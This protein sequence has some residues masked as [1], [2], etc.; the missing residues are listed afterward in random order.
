[1]KE[2]LR[3]LLRDQPSLSFALATAE[4]KLRLG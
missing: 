1:M 4:A 2:L 3:T